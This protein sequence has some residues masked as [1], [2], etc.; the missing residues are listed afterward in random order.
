MSPIAPDIRRELMEILRIYYSVVPLAFAT[1]LDRK[2][3]A[4][5][6]ERELR[7][8]LEREAA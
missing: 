5:A 6:A 2:L 1:S 3:E 8:R 4:V 7:Q